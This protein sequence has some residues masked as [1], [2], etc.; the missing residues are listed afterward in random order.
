[1]TAVGATSESMDTHTA[2]VL[3]SVTA[4]VGVARAMLA[5]GDPAGA[6][7]EASPLLRHVE[8]VLC[9]LSSSADQDPGTWSLV[10]ALRDDIAAYLLAASALEETGVAPAVTVALL[11][12]GADQ[13]QQRLDRLAGGRA[14]P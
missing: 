11:R 3:S 10:L 4:T 13:A 9:E 8:Q 12:R 6:T 14:Q 1:M 2:A 5:I 7:S